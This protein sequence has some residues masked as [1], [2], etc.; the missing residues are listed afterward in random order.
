MKAF[1]IKGQFVITANNLDGL[2]VSKETVNKLKK[3][4][5]DTYFKLYDDDDIL[6]YSGYMHKDIEDEFSPLDWAMYDS[7]CTRIDVRNKRTGKL[8]TL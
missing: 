2:S 5:Y 6:Y 4:G 3:K 8:E 1:G 7:G